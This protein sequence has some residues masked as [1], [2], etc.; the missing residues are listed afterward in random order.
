M[1]FQRAGKSHMASAGAL[2]RK[3]NQAYTLD[4]KKFLTFLGSCI[5]Q[6]E[7]AGEEDSAF[8]FEQLQTYLADDWKPGKSF[9]EPHR[10]L[11]L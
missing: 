9:D 11:G 1:A 7:A 2:D 6:L 8:Y 4:P 3:D 10:V 5:E